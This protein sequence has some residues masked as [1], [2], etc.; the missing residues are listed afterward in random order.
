MVVL[1]VGLTDGF[2]RSDA[3]RYWHRSLVPTLT[4]STSPAARSAMSAMDG[5]STIMPTG[6]EGFQGMPAAER[7][8]PRKTA[9]AAAPRP[10]APTMGSMTRRLPCTGGRRAA[11]GPGCAAALVARHSLRPRTPRK[12][13]FSWAAPGR[14]LVP[15][16]VHAQHHRLLPEGHE[17]PAYRSGTAP[18]RRAAGP[19]FK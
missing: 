8:P 17:A 15:A 9:L 6:M 19:P 7:L 13:L 12:G 2:I 1:V 10:S 11:C 3:V 5:T 16:D 18:P 4:K 14:L